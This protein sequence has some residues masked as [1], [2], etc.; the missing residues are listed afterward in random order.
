MFIRL[1][2]DRSVLKFSKSKLYQ[3]K[4]INKFFTDFIREILTPSEFGSKMFNFLAEKCYSLIVQ[5]RQYGFYISNLKLFDIPPPSKILSYPAQE[6]KQEEFPTEAEKLYDIRYYNDLMDSI[7]AEYVSPALILYSMV[8]QV[9]LNEE[10]SQSGENQTSEHGNVQNLSEDVTNYFGNVI[11]NLSLTEVEKHKLVNMLPILQK[12][13]ENTEP[14]RTSSIT[15]YLVNYNDA[16]SQRLKG[17]FEDPS[18]KKTKKFSKLPFDPLKVELEMLSKS[19]FTEFT[20]VPNVPSKIAKERA[21]RL[22]ELLHFMTSS[23]D[24]TNADVDRALKQFVFESMNITDV[25]KKSFIKKANQASAIPWD[26]PYPN[27]SETLSEEQQFML[28][29]LNLL[30]KRELSN[31]DLKKKKENRVS[32]AST[33]RS[34]KFQDEVSSDNNKDFSPPSSILKSRPSTKLSGLIRSNLVK[35]YPSVLLNPSRSLFNLPLKAKLF[36]KP[37]ASNKLKNKYKT[38]ID[39]LCLMMVHLAIPSEESILSARLRSTL[40]LPILHQYLIK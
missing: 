2:I 6:L 29:S 31:L 21:A 40:F 5:K 32:S 4:N 18:Q 22:Q 19:L 20:G 13:E 8:E 7:P 37:K 30:E 38:L 34:I 24:I 27:I 28:K 9:T 26:D 11:E 25:N 1:N 35:Q 15:P 33:N 16:I 14:K 23:P 3:F 36:N 10:Q 39:L 12:K 17:V